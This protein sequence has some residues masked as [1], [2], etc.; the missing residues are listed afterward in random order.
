MS[1]NPINSI[2]KLEFADLY[3]RDGLQKIDQYFLDFLSEANSSLYQEYLISKYNPQ[4]LNKKDQS[5]LLIK[6]ARILE[7]FLTLFFNIKSANDNL[8]K[9][10][11]DLTNLYVAKRLFIQRRIAKNFKEYTS[12]SAPKYQTNINTNIIDFELRIANKIAL[13]LGDEKQYSQ[14]LAELEQYCVWGFYH[15]DGITKHQN[16]VL[17]KLPKKTDFDNLVELEI[18]KDGTKKSPTKKLKNRDGFALTD[19]GYNLAQVLGEAN[20]C[21][22]CH[23][24]GKDSC[25]FGAKEQDK[26]F[27]KDQFD[28]K[29][30]GCP[31]EEKISEMNLLKSQG[32]SI[33]ALAIAV[34]DN[35]M[36]A[37][38]GHRICNDCMKSCIY[39]IKGAGQDPVDIPQIETKTLK[40]VL[41]LPFGFEIYSLLTRWNPLNLKNIIEKAPSGYKVLVAGLGPSGYTL[42]HYLLNEGHL[43]VGVDGLKI[44]PLD[45]LVCGVDTSG[46]RQKFQPIKDIKEIYEELDERQIGGFGG[47]AEYGITV[48]WDKN[49]LKIIRLLLERRQHFRMFGGFRLGSALDCFDALKEYEFDHVALCLGAGWAKIPDIKN[50]FLK[51]IRMASDFL[52]ALQLTGAERQN[53]PS[54]LQVRLPIL[55]VGSGLTA[56]DTACEALAYYPKQVENFAKYYQILCQKLGKEELEKSWSKEDK[57]VAKEFLEHFEIIKDAKEKGENISKL[58][59]KFGGAKILYRK[60]LQNSPA[61]RLNCEEVQKAFEEGIEFVENV[62]PIEAISDEFGQIKSLKILIDNQEKQIPAG[63][64]FLAAGTTPNKAPFYED[65]LKFELNDGTFQI[66]D[67][68]GKKLPTIASP[69]GDGIGF[70]CAKNDKDKMVSFFG[71]LHPSFGGSVVKAMASAKNGYPI[72]TQA[73]EKLEKKAINYDNFLAKIN[74]NWQVVVSEVNILSD[75]FVELVVF[76]P[77]LASKTKLGHI[78]RLH[79]YHYLAKNEQQTLLAMEGVAVTTYK[80][81]ADKGTITTMIVVAGGSSSLVK[82][83]KIDEPIIFMGPSGKSSEIFTNK[84]IVLIAGGRGIFPLASLAK[85]YKKN[86]CK[87]ILFCGFKNGDD[88]VRYDE[89]RDSCNQLILAFENNDKINQV[90]AK[91]KPKKQGLLEYQ[92][93]PKDK[94]C[95]DSS[96]ITTKRAEDIIFKGNVTSAFV[97]F[98]KNKNQKIAPQINQKID[99]VLTMGSAGMMDRI[100]KIYHL[101]LKEHLSESSIGIVSLSN[102]MQCMLKG[103]CS[104]CLQRKI[105]TKTGKE[106][107]F[108][109]CVSQDQKLS[110]IDFEFLKNRCGQ[111]S[112][113]EKLTAKREVLYTWGKN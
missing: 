81:D 26:N 52:M 78:F 106:R 42:A 18:A 58:L 46:S 25:S 48:R 82:N 44:E 32:K 19:K 36:I 75:Y 1:S 66:I 13:Y 70:I 20:Y 83:L 62:T 16:G 37:G 103:V 57:I 17:F 71:D 112:L 55:V 40:D 6:V 90:F 29:L 88:L 86:N 113:A 24:Q 3:S 77:L 76:C 34:I 8:Q 111:N 2:F 68:L 43:V 99:V 5:N 91:Q 22:Y 49:F 104:Q 102:P 39:Q 100:A 35:P 31:L 54:N 30:F 67:L 60:Q 87:V 93:L 63:S 50:N 45:P 11:N 109:A 23:N 9:K 110:E 27:K 64:L 38:T 92:R 107:F 85:E 12:S 4:A 33:A 14:E 101:D 47:V 95:H 7:D 80:V 105:D 97:E 65:K 21:I 28:N 69:K 89:L 61:Y 73:L 79:N 53:L 84:T 15:K 98:F 41:D 59:Q 51:G 74:H 96:S 108:Y 72:I 56:F 10:H 94:Y